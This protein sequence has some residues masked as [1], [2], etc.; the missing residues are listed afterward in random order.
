MGEAGL[1]PA[2]CQIP[3]R[4]FV[5]ADWFYRPTPLLPLISGLAFTGPV[6]FFVCVNLEFG[7]QFEKVQNDFLG[8]RR[9][10]GVVDVN[11]VLIDHLQD[12]LV[13]LDGLGLRLVSALLLVRE[14]AFQDKVDV[15]ERVERRHH[16]LL[17][18][19]DVLPV[20][21]VTERKRTVVY[22]IIHFVAQPPEFVVHFSE[23]VDL[24]AQLLVA[25]GPDQVLGEL[26]YHLNVQ[27]LSF[28]QGEQC[29]RRGR[30]SA[31]RASKEVYNFHVCLCLLWSIRDSNP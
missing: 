4:Q 25:L 22:D 27:T 12:F 29:S 15:V 31:T 2:Y 8:F 21:V 9:H 11:A 30:F 14:A 1:E 7:M 18:V 16:E 5:K 3:I 10:H 20:V 24:V 19:R 26:G 6:F 23:D 28:H 13:H 17:E